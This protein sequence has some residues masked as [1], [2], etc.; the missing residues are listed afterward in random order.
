LLS[1]ALCCAVVAPTSLDHTRVA[2]P[3]AVA[4]DNTKPAGTLSGGVLSVRL[5][6][7]LARWHPGPTDAPPVETLLFGEEGHAPSNPGPLL[8]APLGTR[9]DVSLRNGLRD[10]MVFMAACGFPCQK[11]DTI[12]VAPSGTGRLSFTPRSAGTFVYWGAPIRHGQL[13]MSDDEMSQLNGVIVVDSGPAR[14]DRIITISTY[15]HVRDTTDESKGRRLLFAFNGRVWPYTER[16]TYTAGDSVHWRIVH[17]GGGEHPMHLH[18]F[19][20][21]VTSRGDGGSVHPIARAKQ[22]LVVTEEIGTLST[23]EMDW[24]PDR[25]GNWLFHCHKPVHVSSERT[26]D[27]FDR[28]HD[29]THH[30]M[31]MTD[32]HAASGM[33]GLVLGITVRPANGARPAG[34][35][36]TVSRRLRLVA[37]KTGQSLDGMEMF[38]Y[39]LQRTDSGAKPSAVS[40]PGPAIIV[41]RGER[42]QITVVNQL[43]EPTAVHWHGVELES[44]YD[45]VAGWSGAGTRVAPLIAPRDSFVAAFTPPRAGTFIYHTHV[46]DINQLIGGLYGPLI[47]LEPGQTWN[48]NTD[49][50]FAIGQ[51]PDWTVVNGSPGMAPL[52]LKAGVP[53]R[54]RFLSMTLDDETDIALARADSVVH[55]KPIAKDAIPVSAADSKLRP[56]RLHFGPGETYDFEFTPRPGAYEMRIYSFTNVLITILA[57]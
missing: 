4:N 7:E 35:A 42:A 12:R 25:P 36:R 3:D 15:D 28:M 32:D 41:T 46:D 17:L 55:W 43:S 50:V 44:Y 24:S 37:Q 26:D 14:P 47:V 51:A 52:R 18:G 21:R 13:A 5:F 49:H 2:L 45:G 29:T 27:L 31:K 53:H 48:E 19:Y 23:F 1:A 57:R 34:D 16:Y 22:P 40:G 11:R 56:A 10:T 54:L 33:G 8:R 39:S 30:D 20:F 9:I 6:A 38:G